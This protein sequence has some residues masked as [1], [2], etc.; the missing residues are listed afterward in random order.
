M[1][2]FEHEAPPVSTLRAGVPAELDRA[3]AR[4]LQR[5]PD[6]R[7]QTPADVAEALAPF[8]RQ[9]RAVP[10]AAVNGSESVAPKLSA[11][12][13]SDTDP[14]L[15]QFL[16][17][18]SGDM[19]GSRSYSALSNSRRGKLRRADIAIALAALAALLAFIMT[20]GLGSRG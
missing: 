3:V 1:A 7:F 17:S 19:S 13:L 12:A 15:D 20:W 9:G 14:A 6:R 5:D 11:T 2:R 8:A 16:E 18:L 10:A 4:M